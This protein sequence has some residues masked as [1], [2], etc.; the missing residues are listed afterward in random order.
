M[1]TGKTSAIGIVELTVGAS[2]RI[3]LPKYTINSDGDN[4]KK[5]HENDDFLHTQN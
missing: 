2:I 3:V 5:E 4:A 1:L